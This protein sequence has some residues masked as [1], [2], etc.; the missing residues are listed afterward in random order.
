MRRIHKWADAYHR[1]LEGKENDAWE[2]A[3]LEDLAL[4]AYL[5]GRDLESFQ[6]L[7]RAHHAYLNSGKPL[8]AARCAFWLG[9]I[10]MTDGE[11]AR[12]G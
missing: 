10:L 3:A 2:P 7:E 1:L 4:A 12:S 9:L 5:T 6:V 11:R 8:K